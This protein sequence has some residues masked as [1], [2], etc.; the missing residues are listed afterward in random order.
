MLPYETRDPLSKCKQ[1]LPFW[2]AQGV[3][4]DHAFFQ[5]RWIHYSLYLIY[6]VAGPNVASSLWI[7]SK[8]I[9]HDAD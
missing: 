4:F 8:F 7:A 5:V 2:G 3:T 1:L 9:P 6:M